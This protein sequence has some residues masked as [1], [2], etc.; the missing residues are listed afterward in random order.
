MADAINFVVEYLDNDC[1]GK[2]KKG[3]FYRAFYQ[4]WRRQSIKII[5]EDGSVVCLWSD[6]DEPWV[7]RR[8]NRKR[9]SKRTKPVNWK[10]VRRE[11][12]K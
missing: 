8:T 9:A 3:N 5:A 2:L 4:S 12:V 11:S 7:W 10:Q 6:N 1:P